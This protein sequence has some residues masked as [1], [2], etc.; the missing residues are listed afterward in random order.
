MIIT[1]NHLSFFKIFS[2][3]V[4][5][6]PNFQIEKVKGLVSNASLQCINNSQILNPHVIFQYCK[7]KKKRKRKKNQGIK[8]IFIR[9]DELTK[10]Q[11][12]LEDRFAKAMTIPG[13]RR[14]H[15]FI[16][17]NKNTIAMKY[18][19]KDQEVATTFSFLNED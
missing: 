2:N 18:C 10:T 9:K 7:K 19:S 8:F 11:E 6:Y 12:P 1:H 14:Y 4:H 16:P 13:T 15:E 17:L 5:F 3:F